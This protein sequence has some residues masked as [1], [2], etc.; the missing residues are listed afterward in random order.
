MVCGSVMMPCW[1]RLTAVTSPICGAMSPA[2]KP[3]SITPIPPSSASATAIAARVMVSMFA[4]T[5]GR[6]SVIPAVKRVV[7]S[8]TAGSRLGTM[9]SCGVSRKSSNVQ[10][11]TNVRR[12]IAAGPLINR[13]AVEQPGAA[14]RFEV[15]LAAPARGVRGVPR[16]AAV[17]LPLPIVVTDLGAP[18]AARRPVGAGEIGAGRK[19]GAVGTRSGEDVVAVHRVAH[20]IDR[21][22]TL[23]DGVLLVDR[24]RGA[25]KL[26]EV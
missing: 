3:R 23:R 2:R 4:E 21:I 10:P 15:R 12:S 13:E 18:R 22:D 26:A 19:G 9:P 14:G 5:T 1:V 6:R 16:L 24:V 20:P 17:A 11:R 25:M 8:I 7:R